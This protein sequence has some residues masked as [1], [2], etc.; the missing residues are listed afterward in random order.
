MVCIAGSAGADHRDPL[1]LEPDRFLR[2]VM[3]VAGLALERVDTG[4]A[5]HGRRRQH[6]DCGDQEARGVAAAVVEEDVP[7]PRVLLIMRGGHAAV[8]PNVAPQVELVRDIIQIPLVFGLTR[9]VLLPVPFL[10][11]LLGKGIAVGPAFGIEAGAGIAVPVPGAADAATGFEHAHLETEFA[12]PIK[13]VETGNAGADD[14]GVEIQA[15]LC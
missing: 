1:A 9:E 5:R 7:A 13:L 4:N 10:E 15:G 6:A 12:Q 14:D 3:G 8:E 11:Q 2:P